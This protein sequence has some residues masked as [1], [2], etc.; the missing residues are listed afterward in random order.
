MVLGGSFKEPVYAN[1]AA[2]DAAI[3]SPANGMSVYLTA[4]GYFTD[5]QG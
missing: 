2:R 5:Y 4:E 3:P 1:A